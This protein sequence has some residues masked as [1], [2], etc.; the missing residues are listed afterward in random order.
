MNK[1]LKKLLPLFFY[2]FFIIESIVVYSIA[3][4]LGVS[5]KSPGFIFVY[6]LIMSP[7]LIAFFWTLGSLLK[8]WSETL[9]RLFHTIPIIVCSL[10]LVIALVNIIHPFIE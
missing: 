6:I 4:H 1:I 8:K 9:C 7:T 3:N 10:S 5:D 2:L